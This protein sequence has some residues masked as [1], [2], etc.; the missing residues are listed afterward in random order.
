MYTRTCSYLAQV[1]DAVAGPWTI[2]NKNVS[3]TFPSFTSAE[4]FVDQRPGPTRAGGSGGADVGASVGDAYVLYSSISPDS[5]PGRHITPA[6]I[7]KLDP[8]W[9]KSTGEASKP[10][11]PSD[12][13]EILFQRGGTY[14]MLEGSHCCFCRGGTDLSVYTSQTTPL[15]Q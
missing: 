11:G 7:E 15:G 6:V 1:A 4:I 10:F 14:Y 2:A 12:E 9:T 3:L 8:T 5:K 13:G